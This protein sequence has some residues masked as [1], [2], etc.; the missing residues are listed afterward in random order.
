MVL[1]ADMQLNSGGVVAWILVGLLAGWLAGKL[2][3]GSGFGVILDI[4]A[5]LVGALVGG[6]L[7][8][9]LTRTDSGGAADVGFWGSVVVAF[10]GACLM[11]LVVRALRQS[12]RT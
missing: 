4:V 3:R 2:V 12:W 6:V 7:F 9:A 1:I 8:S 10:F 11:L 5:G